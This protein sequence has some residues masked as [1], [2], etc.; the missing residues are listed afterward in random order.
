M[1]W[2]APDDFLPDHETVAWRRQALPGVVPN[3]RCNSM[4]TVT[5]MVRAAMDVAALPDF[6]HNNLERL[7]EPLQG[8]DTALWLL[9]RPDC[10]AL[11]SVA[12]LFSELTRNIRLSAPH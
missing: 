2:I 8:Y 3:Y 4:I 5:E 11:R 10:R 6:L 7:S 1:D 9:T 12:T